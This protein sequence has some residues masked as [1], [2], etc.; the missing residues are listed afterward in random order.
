MELSILILPKFLRPSWN[1]LIMHKLL[2]AHCLEIIPA[3]LIYP[4]RYQVSKIRIAEKSQTCLKQVL[5]F[6]SAT[7]VE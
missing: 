2:K 1:T 4:S 6:F 3:N 7:L 5:D